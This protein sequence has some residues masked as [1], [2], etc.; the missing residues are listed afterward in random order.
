MTERD[1]RRQSLPTHTTQG[2]RYRPRARGQIAVVTVVAAAVALATNP[3]LSLLILLIGLALVMPAINGRT[4]MYTELVVTWFN[5]RLRGE[6]GRLGSVRVESLL[7]SDDDYLE[8]VQ[9]AP[10]EV[11]FLPMDNVGE[12]YLTEVHTP[13]NGRHTLYVL[14]DSWGAA[15]VNDGEAMLDQVDAFGQA[16]RNLAARYGTDLRVSMSR[17]TVPHDSTRQLAYFEANRYLPAGEEEPGAKHLE[18]L[19]RDFQEAIELQ[20][21]YA[22][23]YISS[24][25]LTTVRPREW[26]K[27]KPQHLRTEDIVGSVGYELTDVLMTYLKTHGAANVRRP[28]PYESTI[29]LRGTLDSESLPELYEKWEVDRRRYGTHQFRTLEDSLVMAQGPF[30]QAH[31]FVAK[32]DYLRVA[33]NSYTRTF[34]CPAFGQRSLDPG[35]IQQLFHLSPELMAGITLTYRVGDSKF[36]E[37]VMKHRL[38]VVETKRHRRELKG[39]T[40]RAKEEDLEVQLREQD[41]DLYFSGGDTL[42]LHLLATVNAAELPQLEW[43]SKELIKHFTGTATPMDVVKGETAQFQARLETLGIPAA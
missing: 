33:D 21:T 18:S 29:L 26:N 19:H 14:F 31:E 27:L 41:M 38:N 12:Q 10:V 30:P 43:R 22:V 15:D 39:H 24:I 35:S 3:L 25:S 20:A 13:D 40:A 34:H 11:N 17:F 16:C 6:R 23:D 37:R 1:T 36:E 42:H 28:D 9:T 8:R 2:W 5:A 4:F 32:R 7:Y